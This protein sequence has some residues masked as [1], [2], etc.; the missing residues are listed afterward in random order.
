MTLQEIVWK[1]YSNVTQ[2]SRPEM[3]YVPFSISPLNLTQFVVLIHKGS[4]LC[5]VI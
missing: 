5:N 4:L 3:E 1:D 2:V